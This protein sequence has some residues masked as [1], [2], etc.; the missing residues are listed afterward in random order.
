MGYDGVTIYCIYLYDK[1]NVIWIK[2]LRI[3][4]N[5]NKKENSQID[6]FDTLTSLEYQPNNY[7]PK[8]KSPLNFISISIT[9]STT[10]LLASIPFLPHII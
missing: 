5:I 9:V 7:T 1:A 8:I 6:L 3:F 4:G 2:D 10:I